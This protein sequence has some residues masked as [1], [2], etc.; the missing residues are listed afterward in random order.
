MNL[1]NRKTVVEA[2]VCNF[3]T[4]DFAQHNYGVIEKLKYE[5]LQLE[6]A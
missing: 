1:E 4:N 6:L 2:L 5:Q 3:N